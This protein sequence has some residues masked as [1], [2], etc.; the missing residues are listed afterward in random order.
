MSDDILQRLQRVLE[1]RKD[2]AADDSYTARL[3]AGGL[4][5]ILDKVNEET[6]EV[7]EAARA[8]DNENLVHEVADLWFHTLVMLCR[9]GLSVDAVLAELERRFGV[10][11]L[12]EKAARS[13][14]ENGGNGA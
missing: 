1:A 9:Q 13:S 3:Y 6:V 2:A 4:E 14:A 12:A 11:G 5:H 8:G 10:S 7:V